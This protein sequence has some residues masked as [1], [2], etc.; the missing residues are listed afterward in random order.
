MKIVLSNSFSFMTAAAIFTSAWSQAASG[1]ELIP[2]EELVHYINH[3]ILVMCTSQ[4]T[5]LKIEEVGRM[6]EKT[7]L[8]FL[9]YTSIDLFLRRYEGSRQILELIEKD[10]AINAG[11][12]SPG[13]YRYHICNELRRRI[14]D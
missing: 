2:K 12:I 11:F 5:G 14:A 13:E 8:M 10:E 4:V 7:R 1:S 6:T 9:G 3:H